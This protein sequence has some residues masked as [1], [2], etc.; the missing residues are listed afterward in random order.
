VI[1]LIGTNDLAA[2]R[3]PELAADGIPANLVLL[4]QRLPEARILLLG[5][6]PREEFRDAPL[7]RRSAGKWAHLRLCRRERIVYAEIGDVLL[8]RDG[9]FGATLSPDWLH[10]NAMGSHGLPFHTP[11]WRKVILR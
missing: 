3:S 11:G 10:L 7:R 6:L 1:L 5:L 8:D 9:R 4:R 2:H